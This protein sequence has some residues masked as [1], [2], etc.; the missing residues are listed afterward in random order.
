[1]ESDESAP[2]R[3]ARRFLT[4]YRRECAITRKL[5]RAYPAEASE[6]RPHERSSSARQLAWTFVVEQALMLRALGG[7]PVLTGGG[8]PAPPD[9]WEE[10]VSR[11]ERDG[12][13]VERALE[14]AS[15]ATMD[16]VVQFF[17]GPKEVGDYATAD[18]LWFL[19]HDQIHH[20]GQ[21]SV[22]LRM[23]GGRVPSIYGPSADEPWN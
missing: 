13:S 21:L 16:G 23:A 7:G 5:L 8:F 17:V 11:F 20:R 3:A 1:M 12:E 19:L 18:F 4:T 6:L 22:Y 14:D 9:A 10:V 2:R 15:D